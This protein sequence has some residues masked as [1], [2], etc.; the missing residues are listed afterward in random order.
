MEKRNSNQQPIACDLTVFGPGERQ[1]H[2]AL[3]QELFAGCGKMRELSDGFAFQFP[4]EDTWC[5]KIAAWVMLERRCCPFLSLELVLEADRG[6]VE[7][8]LRG[9]QGT[10]EFIREELSALNVTKKSV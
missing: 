9:P 5:A 7:L 3:S 6:P 10:K 4:G 8:R 1:R 2:L